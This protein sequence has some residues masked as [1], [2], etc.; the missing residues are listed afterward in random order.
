[1]ATVDTKAALKALKEKAKALTIE[2]KKL[3]SDRVHAD[4][5]LAAATKDA[6]KKA[7]EVGKAHFDAIKANDKAAAQ[8]AKEQAKVQASIAK[9]QPAKTPATASAEA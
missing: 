2:S 5:T 6:E 3:A 1:M 7:K 4:K 9:L 8:L